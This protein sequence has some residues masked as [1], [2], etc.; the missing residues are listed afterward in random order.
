MTENIDIKVPW[1]QR[2]ST[3]ITGLS[4][5]VAILVTFSQQG[6]QLVNQYIL[7]TYMYIEGDRT[8]HNFVFEKKFEEAIFSYRPSVEAF[9]DVFGRKPIKREEKLT[10]GLIFTGYAFEDDEALVF[11]VTS[12]SSD[13]RKPASDEP[14][15]M[16]VGFKNYPDF[17]NRIFKNEGIES[18]NNVSI[19]ELQSIYK[20]H[21][22]MSGYDLSKYA[23]NFITILDSGANIF[24]TTA[25]DSTD[26]YTYGSVFFFP[27]STGCG[28]MSSDQDNLFPIKVKDQTPEDEYYKLDNIDCYDKTKNGYLLG[29]FSYSWKK[30]GCSDCAITGSR[31]TTGTW[32]YMLLD[33]ADQ[34]VGYTNRKLELIKPRK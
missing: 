32:I 1:Y 25:L 15:A 31:G 8:D 30:T 16:V 12:R 6:S 23:G 24:S 22:V 9:S 14:A 34:A 19:E 3:Y 33:Y 7:P 21:Y 2:W 5:L 4:G 18:I 13:K 27:N 28:S 11:L 17:I 10:E 20:G 26:K 29:I